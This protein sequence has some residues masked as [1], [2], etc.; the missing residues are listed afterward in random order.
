GTES[1]WDQG[2]IIL[3]AVM[4]FLAS[5]LSLLNLKVG[6]IGRA[7]AIVRG[8]VYT[9]AATVSPALVLLGAYDETLGSTI[10]TAIS[11]GLATLSSLVAIF[12]GKAQQ[13]ELLHQEIRANDISNMNRLL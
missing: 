9:L 8:A 13:M 5:L 12:V 1:I 6:E 7:W 11:L 10:L 3:G 2:L 4:Q